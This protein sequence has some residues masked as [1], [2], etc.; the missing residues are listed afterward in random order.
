M[1]AKSLSIY[2]N[3]PSFKVT[4]VHQNIFEGMCRHQMVTIPAIKPF[5]MIDINTLPR[6]NLILKA[7]GFLT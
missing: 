3:V 2:R 1:K 6:L 5:K 4:W 7:E